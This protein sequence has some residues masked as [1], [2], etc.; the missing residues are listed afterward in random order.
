MTKA[1]VLEQSDRNINI[2]HYM[3]KLDNQTSALK[4]L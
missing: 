4:M 1:K 3:C 2:V